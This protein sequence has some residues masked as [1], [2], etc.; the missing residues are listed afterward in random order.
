MK[1]QKQKADPINLQERAIHGDKQFE[2]VRVENADMGACL[3]IALADEHALEI[4][5]CTQTIKERAC[6]L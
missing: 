6:N 3:K 2:R 5:Q 4:Q 1:N